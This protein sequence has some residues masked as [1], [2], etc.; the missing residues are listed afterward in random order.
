MTQVAHPVTT[1]FSEH[2]KQLPELAFCTE[3]QIASDLKT[4]VRRSDEGD[5]RGVA[6]FIATRTNRINAIKS[7]KCKVAL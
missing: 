1:A 2:L 6:K 7:A 4:L 3:A 5:H